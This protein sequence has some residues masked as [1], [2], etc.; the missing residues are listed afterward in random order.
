MSNKNHFLD[1]LSLQ[2][3]NIN[4]SKKYYTEVFGFSV[5]KVQPQPEHAVV[6]ENEAGASFAIRLPLGNLGTL[7]KL[8]TGAMP[9]FAVKDVQSIFDKIKKQNGRLMQ[10]RP[11]E[12]PF[13]KFFSTIDPDGYVLTF[14]QL[15]N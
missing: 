1:F 5:A 9:W 15:E 6:F 2:V 4:L 13:G 3:R 12:G 10:D 11:Q 8:G 7:E 14:H